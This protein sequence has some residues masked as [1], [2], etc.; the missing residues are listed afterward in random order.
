VKCCFVFSLS[1]VIFLSIIA[2]MLHKDS[3]YIR[4]DGANGK[5]KKELV[6]GVVGAIV[7]YIICMLLSTYLWYRALTES[8]EDPRLIE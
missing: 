2:Y 1:G 3:I 8:E 6:K 7:M 4:I 5:K